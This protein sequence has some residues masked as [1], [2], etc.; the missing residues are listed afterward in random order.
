[1][2]YKGQQTKNTEAYSGNL[3]WFDTIGS[4]LAKLAH[5]LN[6][7]LTPVVAYPELIKAELGKD[8]R[9]VVFLEAIEQSAENIIHIV[10]EMQALSPTMSV[11]TET[12]NLNNLVTR[13]VEQMRNSEQMSNH[14]LNLELAENLSNVRGAVENIEKAITHILQNAVEAMSGKS[15]TLTVRSRNVMLDGPLRVYGGELSPGAYVCISVSDTG[16]GIPAELGEKIF[17]PFVTTKKGSNKR[18][19]GLGLS[20]VYRIIRDHKG[21]ILFTSLPGEGATFDL[22]FPA[23]SNER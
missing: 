22:Y 16:P 7:L 20:I 3:D 1:M 5:D 13:I 4:I 23:S 11:S 19:A 21:G 14:R 15:G 9:A 8:S 12:F 6:N 18:G 10:R 2:E 17:I